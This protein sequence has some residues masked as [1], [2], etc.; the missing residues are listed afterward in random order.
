MGENVSLRYQMLANWATRYKKS[1]LKHFVEAKMAG[2]TQWS[3]SKVPGEKV[4][5][6]PDAVREDDTVDDECDAIDSVNSDA[7]YE[8]D[9]SKRPTLRQ[10]QDLSDENLYDQ[11]DATYLSSPE[12]PTK[13]SARLREQAAE[14][15]NLNDNLEHTRPRK[16]LR[17][18]GKQDVTSAPLS[19]RASSS[20]GAGRN[21]TCTPLSSRATSPGRSQQNAPSATLS[22]RRMHFKESRR[23]VCGEE[24]SER[25]VDELE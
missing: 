16:I 21:M 20:L 5:Y 4:L 18:S 14:L 6:D 24:P 2:G 17:S 23:V 12:K 1:D 10:G 9:C 3:R 25:E 13:R 19:S 7:G 8:E 11:S 15:M 22:S